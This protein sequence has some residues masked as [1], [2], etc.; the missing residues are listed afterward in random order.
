MVRN[1]DPENV[2]NVSNGFVIHADRLSSSVL[3]ALREFM[4]I[5]EESDDRDALVPTELG[6]DSFVHPDPINFDDDETAGAGALL[7]MGL[8][9]SYRR[10]PGVKSEPIGF[11]E[12]VPS[13]QRRSSRHLTSAPSE[14]PIIPDFLPAPPR[15]TKQDSFVNDPELRYVQ[16][17]VC[18]WN[19]LF[20]CAILL[21]VANFM[22]SEVRVDVLL[23]CLPPKA[24][25]L[26]NV[27]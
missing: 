16:L 4:K 15:L 19:D 17:L 22:F 8:R 26:E 23:C 9:D 20:A 14:S 3:D 24:A 27:L 1:S 18:S 12:Y 6:K 25:E 7:A 10:V 21:E 13:L 5:L 2:E 11:P